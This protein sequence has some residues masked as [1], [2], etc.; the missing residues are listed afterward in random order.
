MLRSYQTRKQFKINKTTT[1]GI[2]GFS[3]LAILLL[4]LFV[5]PLFSASESTH[6]ASPTEPTISIIPASGITMDMTPAGGTAGSFGTATASVT[7]NSTN[8]SGYTFTMNTE[9]TDPDLKNSKIDYT[10]PT[11]ADLKITNLTTSTTESNFSPNKWGY[12]VSKSGTYLKGASGTYVP[13]PN[14][15]SST[16]DKQIDATTAAGNG[17]YTFTYGVKAN[18][19]LPAGAYNNT[20]VFSATGNALPKYSLT[21]N[22]AGSGVSSVKVCLVS[23]NCSGSD[24]VGTVSSSGGSVANLTYSDAYYLYPTFSSNYELDNWAK[25]SGQGTLSSTTATNPTFTIGNGN[26][27]VTITGKSSC[28]PAGGSIYCKVAAMSKGTQTVAQLRTAID[29]SNSGVYEYNSSI[30]G[31]DS[32]ATKADGT[33]ATIYYYRGI[34]DN[35]VGSYGSDGDNA[36]WPNTVV[37]STATSKSGLT[38]SDTC[39]RIVRT[40]GSGGV[41]MIYQGNW[42]ASGTSGSCKNSTTNAQVTTST[43]N[44]TSSTYR[45][46]VRVGYTHNSTY[47]TN[48]AKTTTI[49]NIFRTNST[50]SGNNTDSTIKDYIEDTWFPNINSYAS[51]L[52]QSAGWCND[53]TMNTDTS[54][55]TP[56]AESTSGIVTYG[57]S[58]SSITV[59]Y[60]GPYMRTRTTYQSPTLACAKYSNVDRSTVDLYTTSSASNG[61]K[62]LNKPAALLTADESAFAGSGY[63]SSITPYHANSYL[64]SGSY[65]WLLSPSYRHSSGYVRGFDLRS[66]GRLGDSYAY[67]AY[68]VRPAISLTSGTVAVSGTGAATDPWI[69]NP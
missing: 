4:A 64:R 16:A 5:L 67:S 31:A 17:T 62:Q 60:F 56:L 40:T 35:T 23:G 19:N 47:A 6:A 10:D 46:I 52:E 15:G 57:T 50:V 32:D 36:A 41:K 28:S 30:F 22:F 61:N 13:V 14:S 26:G 51:K 63:D 65:F 3:S 53:R 8:V 44:G 54:W 34:L 1:I 55:T 12:N 33:K 21:I 2:V 43:F 39:W 18:N 37:L 58:T 24:L 68:G 7:V 59:Y 9:T 49:A 25:T 45:Q 38:T 69:V 42:T 27:T 66:D 29:A 20:L 48:S 11:K